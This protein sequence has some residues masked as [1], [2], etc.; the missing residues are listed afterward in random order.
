M[1][2]LLLPLVVAATLLASTAFAANLLTNGSFETWDGSNFAG[3]TKNMGTGTVQTLSQ[4]ARDINNDW[5]GSPFY[6]QTAKTYYNKGVATATLTQQVDMTPGN[7]N[8]IFSGKLQR[9]VL[10]T[11]YNN[12]PDWGFFTVDLFIDTAKV[13]TVT[14]AANN[15]TETP[16]FS[17]VGPV[18]GFAKV[19]FTMGDTSVGNIS[20]NKSYDMSKF[21]SFVLDQVPEPGSLLA[22][23]GGL[24]GFAGMVIRR[25]Q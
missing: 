25:R 17:Y 9:V 10:D 24:A 2:K 8:L 22:L 5:G 20:N 15:V 23:L 13:Y 14:Y 18:S 11:G 19:V 16:Y 1:R 7:Y 4:Q 3:W 6:G 12:H 21:D